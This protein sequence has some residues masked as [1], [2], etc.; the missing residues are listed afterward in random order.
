MTD[1]HRVPLVLVSGV[2]EAP[3]RCLADRLVG[4]SASTALVHHD[5][6]PADEGFVHR[7]VRLGDHDSLDAVPLDHDCVSCTLREDLLPLLRRLAREPSVERIVLRLD[8]ALEPE[9]VCEELHRVL[10]DGS[11]VVEDV[12]IEAVATAID[13]A[14]WLADA[15]G[16]EA[17]SERGLHAGPDDDRTLA[18]VAVVQAE[19]ADV[20]VLAGHAPD[21]WTA[22]PTGAVLERL[23]PR[24]ALVELSGVETQRLVGA[25]GEHAFRGLP[26]DPG[27]AV[28]SGEPPL[29]PD[30][31]V[32]LLSFTA[33]R[34]F[35]PQRLH[36]A[37]DV[38]LDGVV[39]TRGRAWIAS[40]PDERLWI[41]SAGGGLGIRM[42]GPWLDSAHGPAWDRVSAERRTIASLRWHPRWG[43]RAQELVILAHRAEP[44][45]IEHELRAAL[46]TDE[47]LA[48]GVE[49]WR[50][51]PDPFGPAPAT[52]HDPDADP[53]ADAGNETGN[54][55][56][57]PSEPRDPVNPLNTVDRP[58]S[59]IQ[60]ER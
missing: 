26:R 36:T 27:G 51:Y 10:L 33:R 13:H 37:V 44:A 17:L 28:L 31:G 56:G 5:L 19:F 16:D 55:T 35:H 46:L 32:S 58:D 12:R 41:E 3:A 40:R 52:H 22:A 14:T 1:Q 20:L 11:P 25:V 54:D 47:E 24:A 45:V 50:R 7:Y 53:E 30:C 2:A 39:C 21:P 4:G 57:E 29:E 48:E 9:Q 38:L 42:S 18:Q 8:E 43:D 60:E 15:T 34:P 49:A 6:R 59:R 23:A